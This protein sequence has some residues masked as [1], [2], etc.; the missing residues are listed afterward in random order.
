MTLLVPSGRCLQAKKLLTWLR[1]SATEAINT[2]LHR[3]GKSND[4]AAQEYGD[5]ASRSGVLL[6]TYCKRQTDP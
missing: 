5:H 3:S 4:G 1:R 2:A 6:A